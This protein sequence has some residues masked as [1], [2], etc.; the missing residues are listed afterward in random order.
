MKQILLII[1]YKLKTF[2]RLNTRLDLNSII[3][4][5]GSSLI[6]IG[7]A[8]GAFY[9]T[10][11]T[12]WFLISEIKIGLFLLHEFMSITLFIFFVS[13]NIGNIIVSYSTLYKSNEVSY[14]FT[15]PIIPSKIF[16]LKFLDNFFYSSSTLL[17]ILVSVLAGYASYFKINFSSLLILFAGNFIPFMLSAGSLGVIILMLLIRLA[18]KI[19][20]RKVIYGFASAYLLFILLFFKLNSPLDLAN[21]VLKQYPFINKDSYLGDLVPAFIK[22]L[23]NS[24]LAES[25]YWISNGL[26]YYSLPL[27]FLQI[28]VSILLFIIVFLLGRKWFFKTWLMNLSLTAEHIST[29][30]Q[31]L[32]LFAFEKISSLKPVTESLLKRDFLIFLREPS[33][34]LHLVV[35]LMLIFVFLIS[36]KGIRY[37]GLGNFYLQTGIYLSVFLFNLLLI[38]T[39]SLRFIF[40]LISL[41]GEAY[42]KLKSAPVDISFIVKNKINSFGAIVIMISL[43]LSYF[44][45]YRFAFQIELIAIIISFVA[46][47]TIISINYGMGGLFAN[48]KEKNAIRIASSQGASI[49]FLINIVYMLFIIILIYHPI[50]KYFLSIMVRKPFDLTTMLFPLIPITIV[51]LIGIYI[52]INLARRSLVRDL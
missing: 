20:P 42:W 50:S 17:L 43:I 51:S 18:S 44:T 28:I 7:F 16:L 8:L 37:V 14:F 40:P 35:L 39:L 46:A 41:E 27:T 3:K 32:Y 31:K 19:N 21:S 48:Y 49:T 11:R 6:Y 2:I 26:I 25:A 36:V 13:V 22:Y 15:K 34:W 45:N 47:I 9:F 29:K 1:S 10:K 12:I 24:W 52:S 38:S 5:L 33:Q 4:N 30:R 23:P